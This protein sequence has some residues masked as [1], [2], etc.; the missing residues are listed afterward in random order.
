MKDNTKTDFFIPV[1]LLGTVYL[2]E[3]YCMYLLNPYT[4]EDAY[5]TYRFSRNMAAGLGP[6]FNAGE[7][8]EGYSNFLWM[9]AIALAD[10]AGIA[11]TAFSQIVGVICNTLTFLLVWYIPRRYFDLRGKTTFLGPLLYILFLPFHYYAFSGLETSLYIFLVLLC[12]HAVLWAHN[13][14]GPFAVCCFLFLLTALTR[15]EGII[16]FVFMGGYLLFRAAAKKEP[17]KPYIPG[18][19]LFVAGYGIFM[20]WRL[21]YYGL[22]FP[23]TYYA[24]GSFPFL[25]RSALGLLINKGFILR[26]PHFLLF[27]LVP[28][29]FVQLRRERKL[30]AALVFLCAGLFFSIGFSGFDWMPFFRYTLPVVPVLIVLCQLMFSELWHRVV[31]SGHTKQKAVWVCVSLLFIGIAAEQFSQDLAFNARWKKISDYAFHNQQ[32]A[33]DWMR[34]QLG[35]KPLI[36]MGDVGRLAYFSE[37]RILDVFGL[38]SRNFGAV[39]KAYGA[40]DI[41]FLKQTLSFDSYKKKELELLLDVA[42]DYVMLYNAKIKITDSY[43]GSTAGLVERD[44]FKQAYEYMTTFYIIPLFTSDA[45]PK[46]QHSIDVLDL[47]AGLLAWMT[48]GWGYDVYVRRDAPYPRFTFET[49]PGGLIENIA[50]KDKKNNPEFR[51]QNPE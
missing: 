31:L 41:D 5:I 24:K 11:V 4:C 13:R 43:P 33:G 51:R 21:S 29:G 45:W 50:V 22:P 17:L 9:A 1:V 40:P 7:Q 12:L 6:V 48:N 30:A 35:T 27:L 38:T 26:Y 20:L 19:A 47:S 18:V 37:A 8:V 46:L 34:K 23:N 15:P 25:I 28:L 44:A 14:T 36:A 2:L 39:K 3:L 42:P 49:T 16:F 32:T 10:R